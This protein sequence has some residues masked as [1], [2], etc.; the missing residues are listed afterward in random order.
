M[1]SIAKG[2]LWSRTMVYNSDRLL[3]GRRG[4]I[5]WY[6][7]IGVDPGLGTRYLVQ[8]VSEVSGIGQLCLI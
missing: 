1:L 5:K 3:K 4:L 7:N 8:G 6:E 2:V